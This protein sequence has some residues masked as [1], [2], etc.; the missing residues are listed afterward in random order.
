MSLGLLKILPSLIVHEQDDLLVYYSFRDTLQELYRTVLPD[1]V[2]RRHSDLQ[3]KRGAYIVQGPNEIW[4][5]DGYMKLQPFGIEVYAS[6]D[7][8]SCY[9]IWI[10]VGISA[11]TQVSVV[12]QYLDTV[13]T[14]HVLP[15][16]LQSDHGTETGLLG[17]A[18][19]ELVR[20]QHPSIPIED[21]YI[22]GTSTENQ[23][24]EA[25]WGQLT[26]G[27]T[28]KWR[29]CQNTASYSI[30]KVLIYS[31]VQEYFALLKEEGTFSQHSLADQIALYA[32]YMPTLR[33][34]VQSFVHTWNVHHIR[35][36][37]RR[38]TVVHGKPYMNYFHPPN[39]VQDQGISVDLEQL[40]ALQSN[41]QDWGIYPIFHFLVS[42]YLT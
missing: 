7:A 24:I 23:R 8:Y 30:I 6:I 26:K 2:L 16:K 17:G 21:C 35:R 41:V 10:Y 14:V 22:Y 39:G 33:A 37:P 12:R 1:A 18:H 9:V 3:R 15:K 25:W 34:E 19:F 38:P 27:L 4:A 13:Q 20:A 32:V 5:V 11:R 36:Q 29:V 28:F 42:G 40:S 31:T